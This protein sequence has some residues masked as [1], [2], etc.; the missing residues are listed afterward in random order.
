MLSHLILI[1]Q[2]LINRLTRPHRRRAAYNR[3]WHG[4]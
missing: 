3:R 4:G 1:T 2:A